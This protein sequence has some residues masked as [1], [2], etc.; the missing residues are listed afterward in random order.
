M[1]HEQPAGEV[2]QALMELGATICTPKSPSCF[3]CPW[4]KSC[5]ALK[6]NQ[7]EKLPLPKARKAFEVWLWEPKLKLHKD[8]IALVENDYAP[9]LKKQWFF[10]GEARKLKTPPKDFDFKHSITH[11]QIYVRMDMQKVSKAE[12][13]KYRWVEPT[14]LNSINPASLLKKALQKRNLL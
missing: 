6:E 7:I 3:L 11:H 10:P 12:T 14:S 2:N 1:V 13:S 9:F 8:K 4:N 5:V